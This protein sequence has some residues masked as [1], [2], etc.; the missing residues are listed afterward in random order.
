MIKLIRQYHAMPY[1]VLT[2]ASFFGMT[3]HVEQIMPAVKC[4]VFV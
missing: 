3:V 1:G 4:M 2:I